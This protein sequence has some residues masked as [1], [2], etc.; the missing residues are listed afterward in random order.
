MEIRITAV[1]AITAA[2]APSPNKNKFRLPVLPLDTTITDVI[3]AGSAGK[4]LARKI[5]DRVNDH[6]LHNKGGDKVF[7]HKLF[8]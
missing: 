4:K 7:Q 8:P 3:A 2:S 5:A 1:T 6:E